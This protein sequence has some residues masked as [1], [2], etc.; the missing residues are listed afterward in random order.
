MNKIIFILNIILFALSF[1]ACANKN[2]QIEDIQKINEDELKL[3]LIKS[4]NIKFYDF[5]TLQITPEI[6]LNVF[7][8]GKLLG[9]FI[10]KDNEICFQNDCAPKWPASRAFFGNVSYDKLFEEILL[11]EDIFDGI[12]KE[13]GK[14]GT[15]IQKFTYGGEDM[16]Y[17][18]S[19]GKIYFKNLTNGVTVSIIDYKK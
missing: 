10:I 7:Q 6:K 12:G 8:L 9:S 16:Y 4:K 18:R 13:L 14:D 19:N 5:G 17:E 3:V 11:K 15:I 2:L 1:N